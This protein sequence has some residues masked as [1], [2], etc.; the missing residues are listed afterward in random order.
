MTNEQYEQLND[1]L[2]SEFLLFTM[3][4]SSWAAEHIPAGAIVVFQTDD[5]GFNAWAREAAES[6]WRTE[7]PPRPMVLVYLRL[8]PQRSRIVRADAT[9]VSG[10]KPERLSRKQTSVH[11]SSKGRHGSRLRQR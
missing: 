11:Q 3:E 7:K 1:Q 2:S 9:L 4:H 8:R 10:A 6:G 5:E